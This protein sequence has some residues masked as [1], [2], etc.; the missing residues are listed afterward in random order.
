MNPDLPAHLQTLIETICE[1]GC[2]TVNEIIAAL[3]SGNPVEE[4]TNLDSGE[5]QQILLELKQIMA[6][7]D[8]EQA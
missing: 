2:G 6:V 8:R 7:Y 1:R 3:E 5:R 4:F